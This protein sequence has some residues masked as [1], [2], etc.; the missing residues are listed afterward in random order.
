MKNQI[1]PGGKFFLIH[2]VGLT[3]LTVG[4]K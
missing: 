4:R 1:T 3:A 2:T